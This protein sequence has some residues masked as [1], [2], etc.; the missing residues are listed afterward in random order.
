[1]SVEEKGVAAL[2]PDRHQF[3]L[4]EPDTRPTI[5][6]EGVQVTG[7]VGT[8]HGGWCALGVVRVGLVHGGGKVGVGVKRVSE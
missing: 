3:V 1:M 4:I 8:T 7:L 5:H 6:I 2:H